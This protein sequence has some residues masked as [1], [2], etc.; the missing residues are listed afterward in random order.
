MEDLT[1]PKK[2]VAFCIGVIVETLRAM[3]SVDSYKKMSFKV[4]V[5]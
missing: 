1:E 3:L 4:G 2:R 5:K